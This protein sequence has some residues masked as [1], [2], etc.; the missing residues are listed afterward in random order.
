MSLSTSIC[1][2]SKDGQFPADPNILY[3]W[4]PIVVPGNLPYPTIDEPQFVAGGGIV[5]WE[6]TA[7]S[8]DPLGVRGDII[9]A[10]PFGSDLSWDLALSSASYLAL[11]YFRLG[12]GNN[13]PLHVEIERGLFPYQDLGWGVP[14][15]GDSVLV[16]G[17][18]IM[19]CGHPATA[20]SEIHP[21]SFL[22]MGRAVDANTTIAMAFASPYRTTQLYNSQ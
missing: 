20:H 15:I 14:R 6:P 17:D 11:N 19:D 2:G 10:H 3:E 16:K 1:G 7:T 21:P 22:A 8:S 12:M 5:K 9:F 4:A 18:W 13:I